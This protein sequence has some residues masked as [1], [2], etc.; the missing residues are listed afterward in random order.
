MP[1]N[2]K[3]VDRMNKF[4][5]TVCGT[6]EVDK[7]NERCLAMAESIRANRK[8]CDKRKWLNKR[9]LT[10]NMLDVIYGYQRQN[11]QRQAGLYDK[12]MELEQQMEKDHRLSIDSLLI[13][14]LSCKR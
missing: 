5:T 14:I 4:W 10:R 3:P 8:S 7:D 6:L 11:G 9:G 2:T 13:S 1:T 12:I